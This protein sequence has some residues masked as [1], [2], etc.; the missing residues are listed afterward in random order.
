MWHSLAICD[1]PTRVPADTRYKGCPWAESCDDC[2]ARL[3]GDNA[4]RCRASDATCAQVRQRNAG[5]GE[6]RTMQTSFLTFLTRTR[7]VFGWK[8]K[9]KKRNCFWGT[10]SDLTTNNTKSKKG[11]FVPACRQLCVEVTPPH[12]FLPPLPPQPKVW[13]ELTSDWS[14]REFVKQQ[15]S[16]GEKCLGACFVEQA[17]SRDAGECDER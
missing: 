2:D 8:K 14:C 13:I 15:R 17:T 6:A 7:E 3:C 12:L 1:C 11:Y 9:K 5:R 4:S 10:D 16:L